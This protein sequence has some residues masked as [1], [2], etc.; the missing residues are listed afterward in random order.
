MKNESRRR[1]NG[2]DACNVQRCSGEWRR[3][4]K[5]QEMNRSRCFIS[6]RRGEWYA[7]QNSC[8]HRQQMALSRGMIGSPGRRTEGCLPFS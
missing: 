8:P 1:S 3:M 6:D 7:T 5:I 4:R 2:F